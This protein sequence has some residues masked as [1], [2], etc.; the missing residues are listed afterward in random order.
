[1]VHNDPFYLVPFLNF[2][3]DFRQNW[4]SIVAQAEQSP[5]DQCCRRN[6]RPFASKWFST[7]NFRWIWFVF[8][9]PNGRLL[10]CLGLLNDFKNTAI[11]F[12]HN[13]FASIHTSLFL[14]DC[15][16]VRDRTRTNLFYG[17]VLMQYRMYVNAQGCLSH[18]MSNDDLALS[19][20]ARHQ[21]P[22]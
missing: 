20:Q 5:Q 12:F 1:M 2:S 19:V 10:F 15:Q 17:Q 13:F 22:L 4:P 21:C 11:D 3:E 16:V 9:E 18:G 6:R 8:K 14:S 7:N